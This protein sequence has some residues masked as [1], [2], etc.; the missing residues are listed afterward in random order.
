M[1]V[2]EDF[3]LFLV[4]LRYGAGTV[5]NRPRTPRWRRDETG[6]ELLLGAAVGRAPYGRR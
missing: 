3:W 4:R 2:Q 6:A 1:T 5:E